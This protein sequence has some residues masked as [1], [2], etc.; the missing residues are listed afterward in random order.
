MQRESDSITI[1]LDRPRKII[2]LVL[3]GVAC[4]VVSLV[5]ADLALIALS[6]YA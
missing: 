1:S 3:Y 6:R 5:L 2:L 4:V